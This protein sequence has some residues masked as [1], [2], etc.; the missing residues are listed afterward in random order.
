MEPDRSVPDR[1]PKS[2]HWASYIPFHAMRSLIKWINALAAAML[3]AAVAACTAAPE[4]ASS[5]TPTEP[6][7]PV[8]TATAT[9]LPAATETEVPA[10][11]ETSQPAAPTE[12]PQN[13]EFISPYAPSAPSGSAASLD[14]VVLQL[15]LEEGAV[16]RI[17]TLTTQDIS[18]TLEGQSFEIGQKIGFEYTYT[19]TSREPN[20]SAWVDVIYTRAI[21]ESETPFGSSS[22]DS[23]DSPNQIPEGAEGFAAVVGTG[24]SMQIGSNGEILSIE[25][26]DEMLDQILSGLNLPDAELR[27]AFE[28][29]M[30]QQYSEQAMKDQLGNL[31]FDFPEG[32]L[33]VG[34]SWS[35][36]QESNVMLPI[37][38]ETT[39]TLLDFD[40][41][42]A[43][44]EV[45]S[46]IRT[47]EGEG[48]MD[49]GL[50]AFDFTISGTQEGT[51]QVDLN[52]GLAN[53]VI[54]QILVGEMQ[55]VIEGEEISVPLNIN[56]TVQVESVQLAP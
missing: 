32:S 39:Y 49:F 15:D 13:G 22:Y 56:Q 18:Q 20:G 46:E 2:A 54:D 25:G 17:R 36:T 24:F 35:S 28:L 50:F 4:P 8:P 30:R 51:I 5:P 44:I 1:F 42:T 6:A 27:Q 34:D 16:Y 41:N 7:S 53:S 14:P 40:E 37:I 26:L 47:G 21:F 52:T 11:T 48:G 23:A 3:F 33:Q 9:E 55:M 12:S 19:V 10:A 43:L 45:R 31:L 29:T 38:A